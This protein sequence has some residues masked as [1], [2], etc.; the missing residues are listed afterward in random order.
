MISF[1]IEDILQQVD[2]NFDEIETSNLFGWAKWVA[3]LITGLAY[4]LTAM[5]KYG[6]FLSYR[7]YVAATRFPNQSNP[8]TRSTCSILELIT[9]RPQL[10]QPTDVLS[11]AMILR[12]DPPDTSVHLPLKIPETRGEI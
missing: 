12:R 3:P 1:E 4:G 7:H 8:A 5:A 6:L 10:D 11:T 2:L 9:R